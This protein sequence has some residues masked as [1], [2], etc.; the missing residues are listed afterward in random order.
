MPVGFL[1][2]LKKF[3]SFLIKILI[4]GPS[5]ARIVTICGTEGMTVS[6]RCCWQTED[7][8]QE[9]AEQAAGAGEAGAGSRSRLQEQA[10]GAVLSSRPE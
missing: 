4:G 10:A 1:P 9:Q 3:R 6:G 2:K 5:A 8:E 7:R